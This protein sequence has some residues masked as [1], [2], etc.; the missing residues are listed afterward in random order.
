L[1]QITEEYID[2]LLDAWHN[3]LTPGFTIEELVFI[4]T[5][6]DTEQYENWERTGHIPNE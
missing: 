6:W 2:D 1:K 3:D 5:G 4:A